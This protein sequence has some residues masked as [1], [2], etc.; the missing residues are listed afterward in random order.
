MAVRAQLAL[1]GQGAALVEQPRPLEGSDELGF[2]Y[3]F[4]LSK[5]LAAAPV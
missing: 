2:T 4:S 1:E 5:E 3:D